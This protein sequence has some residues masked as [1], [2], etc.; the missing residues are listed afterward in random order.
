MEKQ[1][2]TP[3]LGEKESF[4][5][6]MYTEKKGRDVYASNPYTCYIN[7]DSPE[8]NLAILTASLLDELLANKYQAFTWS[9]IWDKS[10]VSTSASKKSGCVLL[11][12]DDAMGKMFVPVSTSRIIDSSSLIS[13]M[14]TGE[15]AFVGINDQETTIDGFLISYFHMVNEFV[16]DIAYKQAGRSDIS[17]YIKA[18]DLVAEK[19]FSVG[20]M[21]E[22]QIIQA[23]KQNSDTAVRIYGSNQNRFVP[24]ILGAIIKK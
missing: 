20:L 6:A 24:Q 11:T 18:L 10:I 4:I 16:W 12:S 5:K 13:N 9:S 21:S 1:P 8:P 17:S 23:K 14:P 22:D 19:G 3:L 7:I 15:L 2:K